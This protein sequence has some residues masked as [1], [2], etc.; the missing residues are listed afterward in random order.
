MLNA[1]VIAD[2]RFDVLL[3]FHQTHGKE[4][5][6]YVTEVKDPSRYGV[7]VANDQGMI[8]AFVEKP[9]ELKYGNKINAGMY[10]FNKSIIKR[11]Q[12]KPTSIEID[13]FPIMAKEENLYRLTLEGYWMDVG[14]PSDYLSGQ[15]MFL[16]SISKMNDERLF[17]MSDRIIGNV[18]IH[19]SAKVSLSAVLGPNVVIGPNCI[20]G[21][22]A[23]IKDS[24]VFSD[25]IVSEGSY[26]QGSIIGWNSSIGRW[27]RLQNLCILGQ[28]VQIK[29]ECFLNGTI[30]CPHKG[31]KEDHFKPE[32]ILM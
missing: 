24:C 27:S 2:Y 5:S 26:I 15:T 8:T 6:I 32:E 11:V 20:I 9:K 17:P 25:S 18:V 29:D 30:V 3:K 19:P 4:G 1:D 31:V 10:V 16:N 28:D 7:V 22:S 14:K 12:P 13:I 23:R 21:A